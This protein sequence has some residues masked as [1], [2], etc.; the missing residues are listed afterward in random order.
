LEET[1]VENGAAADAFVASHGQ[2]DYSAT[3]NARALVT[4]YDFFSDGA[5]ATAANLGTK[6]NTTTL[7]NDTW[8]AAQLRCLMLGG[9]GCSVPSV[10]AA[11]A[12][13]LHYA[14]LSANGYNTNNFKDI[15]NSNETAAAGGAVPALA[16]RI[17]VTMGCHG[18]FEVPDREALP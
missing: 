16:G 17:V 18:G 2:L 4:G 8:T 5:A 7:I 11:N 14:L 6:L 9:T 15:I 10:I 12:H 13:W 1:T 3:Q